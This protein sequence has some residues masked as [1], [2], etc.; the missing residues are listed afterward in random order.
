MRSEF[1]LAAHSLLTYTLSKNIED[2]E[3]LGL[4]ATSSSRQNDK[5]PGVAKMEILFPDKWLVNA[6]G[7]ERFIDTYFI[8]RIDRTAVD[9]WKEKCS[10]LRTQRELENPDPPEGEDSALSSPEDTSPD[11]ALHS[12]TLSSDTVSA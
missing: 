5:H 2:V 8:V 1:S 7:D 9:E 4:V 10:A 3:Y 12:S 6:R 11:T